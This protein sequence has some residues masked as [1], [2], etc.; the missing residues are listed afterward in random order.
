MEISSINQY[1]LYSK[2][3]LKFKGDSTYAQKNILNKVQTQRNIDTF[4]PSEPVYSNSADLRASREN[5]EKEVRNIVD[6][7][8]EIY[9]IPEELKP[10]LVI[11]DSLQFASEEEIN[12]KFKEALGNED[13]DLDIFSGSKKAPSDMSRDE[14]I[15]TVS[16]RT[17]LSKKD[18]EKIMQSDN[19]KDKGFYSSVDN[20]ITFY[21]KGY[22]DGSDTI[23]GTIL[24]ELY[25]AKEAV[26][27]SSLQ[28]ED[29]DEIVRAELLKR[30]KEGESRNVFKQYPADDD[31]A[32]AMMTVPVIDNA[33]KNVLSNIAR[34]NLFTDDWTL[35]EKMQK[36]SELLD[37]K[38]PN[39]E[40]LARAKAD[41]GGLAEQIEETALKG[42]V[43][44]D[45]PTLLQSVF[46]LSKK[47]KNKLLFDYMMSMEFRYQYFRQKEIKDAPTT[48]KA[49]EYRDIAKK[50]ISEH[51]GSTQANYAMNVARQS[52]KKTGDA[53]YWEYYTSREEVY[54][55]INSEK[56]EVDMLK[57]K[58]ANSI[59]NT[60]KSELKKIKKQ[61]KEKK[62]QFKEDYK[63]Y[64]FFELEDKFKANPRNVMLRL[65]YYA[66]SY[67]IAIMKQTHS[68]SPVK[69]VLCGAYFLFVLL[70][71]SNILKKLPK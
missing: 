19:G 69:K 16:N 67:E 62:A 56:R 21:T 23:E 14:F 45:N 15:N 63:L 32:S 8:C 33:T 65:K 34:D 22:R 41:L 70:N 50:S 46:G 39:E 64:K 4:T 37:Q 60:P 30:L 38:N 24:H 49:D 31:M 25:H 27:R 57:L 43:Y 42:K 47:E 6:K 10:K 55:R 29:R 13:L 9:G 7:G 18:V 59:G 12:K 26:I 20:S 5:L 48:Q 66:S 40:E 51:I 52:K 44:K 1:I 61:L 54:A 11:V 68:M 58:Y 71:S 53:L 17:G 2:T 35:Y 36:Y 28:Q 3:P